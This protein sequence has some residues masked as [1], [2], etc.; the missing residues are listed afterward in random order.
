MKRMT[1]KLSWIVMDETATI[2]LAA[3][4]GIYHQVQNNSAG[5]KSSLKDVLEKNKCGHH[6]LLS[7]HLLVSLCTGLLM[8]FD[9]MTEHLK[10]M[11]NMATLRLI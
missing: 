2:T 11:W 1:M 10:T 9:F 8:T 3:G 5:T 4:N 7:L 6:P